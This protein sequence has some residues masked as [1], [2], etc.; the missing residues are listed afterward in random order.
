MKTCMICGKYLSLN[1]R[2]VHRLC[3]DEQLA[4][5]QQLEDLLFPEPAPT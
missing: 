2:S 5:T 4:E 3:L 1:E